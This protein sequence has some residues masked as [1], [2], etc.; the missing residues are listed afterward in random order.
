M[1][2]SCVTTRS[3]TASPRPFTFPEGDA[4]AVGGIAAAWSCITAAAAPAQGRLALDWER[5]ARPS[6]SRKS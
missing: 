2:P 3:P 1:K 4:A 5:S 6:W